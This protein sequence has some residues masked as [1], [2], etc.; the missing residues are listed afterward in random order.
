M[1]KTNCGV[2][3][4]ELIEGGEF[5]GDNEGELVVN[6]SCPKCGAEVIYYMYPITKDCVYVVEKE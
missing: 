1:L 2:C 4:T 3:G 5:D 6:L